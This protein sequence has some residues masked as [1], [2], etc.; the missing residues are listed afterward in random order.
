MDRQ[1]A[2][3]NEVQRRMQE[4]GEKALAELRRR[5]MTEDEIQKFLARKN[6][7]QSPVAEPIGY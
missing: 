2:S 3:D 7:D 5:G 1:P 6:R 4:L